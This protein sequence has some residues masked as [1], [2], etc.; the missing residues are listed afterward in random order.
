MENH[1]FS[2]VNPLFL[3]PFSSSQTVN[4]FQR[5]SFIHH[6]FPINHHSSHICLY[7]SHIYYIPIK[8][9]EPSQFTEWVRCFAFFFGRSQ[10]IFLPG[11]RIVSS[12]HGAHTTNSPWRIHTM[13]PTASPGRRGWDVA[14]LGALLRW[15]VG[16]QTWCERWLTTRR[17]MARERRGAETSS[18]VSMAT[19][20][21]KTIY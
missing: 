10:E 15:T 4:V 5:V 7:I 13:R 17:Q 6:I 20:Y 21:Y 12:T 3:W 16:P 2:W 1:Y 8:T 19:L 9:H 18:A 14:L 11:Q